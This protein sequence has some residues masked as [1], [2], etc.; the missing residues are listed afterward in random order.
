MNTQPTPSDLARRL[1]LITG[2]T[3]AVGSAL[4][5]AFNNDGSKVVGISRGKQD[6]EFEA[7][8]YAAD[9]SDPAAI[10]SV[11][12]QIETDHG[13]ATILI[14]NAGINRPALVA[15]ATVPDWDAT[16]NLNLRAAQICS[17]QIVRQMM[18]QRKGVILNISSLAALHPIPGQAAYA[19]AK[20]G[21]ESLTRCL[22]VELAGKNIRVNAIAPGF[23]NSPLLHTM[24]QS[25]KEKL[26]KKIPLARWGTVDEIAACAL[27]LCSNRAAYIT[28]Q[29]FHIDGGIGM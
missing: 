7:A 4:C 11:F 5:R 19:A 6:S 2:S 21:L 27:F 29:I 1:V 16:L 18:H 22:A 28:G 20:G 25:P 3:G 13:T 14:N 17:Q 23:L 12:K 8:H 15:N 26:L 10:E 24:E 9:L